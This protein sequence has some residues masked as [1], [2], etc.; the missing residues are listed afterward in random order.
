ML[1]TFLSKVREEN[2]IQNLSQI[3]LCVSEFLK[4]LLN[5][6]DANSDWI[7]CYTVTYMI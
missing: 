3:D 4:D 5:R 7:T 6:C 1:W 2:T